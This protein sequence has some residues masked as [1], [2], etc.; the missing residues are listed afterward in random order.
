[1]ITA[2]FGAD[3][4][5]IERDLMRC[6]SQAEKALRMS[7]KESATHAKAFATKKISEVYTM[8]PRD[9]GKTLSVK[10]SGLNAQM[11]ASA[12]MTPLF[13]GGSPQPNVPK[14]GKGPI[15]TVSVV[16]GQ[17][18]EFANAFVAAVGTNSKAYA[19]AG[20]KNAVVKTIAQAKAFQKSVQRAG[21]VHL[22]VFTRDGKSR[23]PI[24]ERYTIS[25]PEMIFAR[26]LSDAI[27]KEAGDYFEKRVRH[28]IGRIL[29]GE[30]I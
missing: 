4:R 19:S 25:T 9:V 8:G 13:K 10:A 24:T 26:R 21:G 1:M 27:P 5:N 2:S 7:V 23:L 3:L 11:K 29:S 16:K 15:L 30:K 17:R 22:G 14:F 20:R 6:G 18:K 28:Q 12:P